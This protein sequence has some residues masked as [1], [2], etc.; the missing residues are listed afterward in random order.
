MFRDAALDPSLHQHCIPNFH[1]HRDQYDHFPEGSD[2]MSPI[3][4]SAKL[5]TRV[6]LFYSVRVNC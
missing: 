6:L 1:S 4:P 5:A 2:M 3:S